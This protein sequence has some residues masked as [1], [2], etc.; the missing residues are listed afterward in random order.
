MGHYNAHNALD[1]S[2]MLFTLWRKFIWPLTK[3][4][5][6]ILSQASVSNLYCVDRYL[7]KPCFPLHSYIDGLV[8]SKLLLSP[9]PEKGQIKLYHTKVLLNHLYPVLNKAL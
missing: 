8:H 2:L 9:K 1:D 4:N 3:D 7:A 5:L 6:D